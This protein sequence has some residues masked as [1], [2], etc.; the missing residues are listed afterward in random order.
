VKIYIP[1]KGR[2]LTQT[3]AIQLVFADVPFEIVCSKDDPQLDLY[4]REWGH[5]IIRTFKVSTIHEKRQKILELGGKLVMLDDDQTFY[6][7]QPDG[8]F[9]KSSSREIRAMFK[10]F[11]SALDRYAHAGIVD[12]FMS[13]TTPR[14]EVL[15]RRYNGV[16]GYNTDKFKKPYPKF[17]IPV[18]EEHDVHLQLAAQ[19]FPPIVSCEYS[20]GTTYY[21]PGGCTDER[22][23][24]S[25][26]EGH[27]LFASLW[28]DL[29]KVVPHKSSIS[30]LAI[31]VRWSKAVAV[32][33]T[34]KGS[35]YGT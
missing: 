17:R 4:K 29:V 8:R 26:A 25:E 22:S 20:K 1:S 14:G 19:G 11:D 30:G 7:R 6:A 13:N 5:S 10:W 3:T 15:S 33:K 34:E 28:P 21:N 32:R 16:L 18:S 35:V 9:S 31:R 12:K 27:K 24:R 2:A 23:R